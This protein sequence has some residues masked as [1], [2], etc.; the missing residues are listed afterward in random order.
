MRQL[1][2]A[3]QMQL[4]TVHESA[5]M[6]ARNLKLICEPKPWPRK[7]AQLAMYAG[8]QLHD[9]VS[10]V[11]G[12]DHSA[13]REEEF[14]ACL[15]WVLDRGAVRHENRA[16]LASL[17]W[18]VSTLRRYVDEDSRAF[19]QLARDYLTQEWGV[20]EAPEGVADR[21]RLAWDE[22]DRRSREALR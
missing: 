21:T 1:T 22:V 16:R 4:A 3:T 12:G 6:T 18:C 11:M 5:L 15:K 7:P 14:Q 17:M 9:L 13:C 2:D 20:F 10:R 19:H 8:S